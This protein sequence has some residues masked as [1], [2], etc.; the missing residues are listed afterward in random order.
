MCFTGGLAEWFNSFWKLSPDTFCNAGI[1]GL[2][3]TISITF[4]HQWSDIL[5]H[6]TEISQPC[7]GEK[8]ATGLNFSLKRTH[9]VCYTT[10]SV[11][12]NATQ[13]ASKHERCVMIV[14]THFIYFTCCLLFLFACLCLL[15]NGLY[16]Y[17]LIH[18]LP[19]SANNTRYSVRH[20]TIVII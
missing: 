14:I 6:L 7:R 3:P 12:L 5:N 2:C 13:R 15:L 9:S 18:N 4:W 20:A 10:T 1:G 11:T 8:R 19:S 16:G 17:F